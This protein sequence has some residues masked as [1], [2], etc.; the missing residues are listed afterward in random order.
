LTCYQQSPLTGSHTAQQQRLQLQLSAAA[1]PAMLEAQQMQHL[2]QVCC[3]MLR[4]VQRHCLQPQQQL[5]VLVALLLLL[6][7][8]QQQA[9]ALLEL[10]EL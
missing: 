7:L 6:Q 2:L 3:R 1:Q 5:A 4:Q 8:Q 9:V 10:L